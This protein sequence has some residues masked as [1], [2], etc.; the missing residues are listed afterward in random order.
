[1]VYSLLLS[2]NVEQAAVAL[3]QAALV[4]A[5]SADLANLRSRVEL[6]QRKADVK[7]TASRI[8]EL[9]AS[10]ARQFKLI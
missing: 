3:E 10:A 5:Q 2:N 6:A 4:D 1:M 8:V 9:L 7:V